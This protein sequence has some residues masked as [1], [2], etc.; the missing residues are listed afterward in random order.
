M[1]AVILVPRLGRRDGETW[2][3]KGTRGRGRPEGKEKTR[4]TAEGVPEAVKGKVE[5]AKGTEVVEA[6]QELGLENETKGTEDEKSTKGTGDVE[7]AQGIE[8]LEEDDVF[9]EVVGTV[10]LEDL[11]SMEA[12]EVVKPTV[13]NSSPTHNFNSSYVSLLSSKVFIYLLFYPGPLPELAISLHSQ[14]TVF[15][16]SF[17]GYMIKIKD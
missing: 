10:Q 12:I 16:V 2:T 15:F 14:F 9:Q 6:A 8:V 4:K 17:G 1:S 3:R 11:D 5:A 13:I 7:A